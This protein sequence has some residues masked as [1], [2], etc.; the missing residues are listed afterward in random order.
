M[1]RTFPSTK[2]PADGERRARRGYV[3]QDRSSARLIYA[4]LLDRTLQWIGLA[5]RNAGSVDDLVLGLSDCVVAHQ[6]KRAARPKGVGLKAL[7]LGPGAE[8]KRLADSFI[9]LRQQFPGIP[10]R[11]RYLSN[12]FPSP[13]DKLVPRTSKSSTADFVDVIASTSKRSLAEWRR[14]KWAP[15]I[16]QL[17]EASKLTETDF[18]LFWSSLELVLGAA[19]LGAFEPSQDQECEKQIEELSRA[20]STLV[21]DHDQ[22]RWTREELLEVLNWPDRYAQHYIHSFPVGKYVQRNEETEADLNAKIAVHTKG[23]VSLIGPPGVGKSTLLQSELHDGAGIHLLRYLAFIPGRAQGQGRGE[24]DSFY[25]D[26]SSQFAGLGLRPPRVKED[27]TGARREAFEVLLEKAGE[28]FR[29]RGRRY[30]IVLDGLDHIPREEC[31]DRSLLKA[32]PLPQSLPEGVLFVL[33][34]Q[35]LDLKDIPPSVVEE[36]NDEDRRVYVSPLPE[37]AVAAMANAMGLPIEIS[38]AEIY[39]IT[40]GHPLVSRYLIDKLIESGPSERS[41]LLSGQ[42][43]FGGE[44]EDVYEAAWRSIDQADSS[45]QVK[46]VLSLIAFADGSIEPALLAVATSEQAVESAL[47]QSRHLLDR[48]SAGWTVFHNSFRLFVQNK[49]ILKFGEPD[50]QFERRPIYR[51]LADLAVEASSSSPQ[52]WLQF[53]YLFLAGDLDAAL[54]VAGRSYFADQYCMGRAAAEVKGDISDALRA[55][56]GR[57]DPSKLFDVLLASDEVERRGNVIEGATSLIDA[58]LAVGDLASA[59]DALSTVNDDGKQWLVI[60]GLLEAGETARARQLFDLE[61]PFRTM[62]SQAQPWAQRAIQFLDED[63]LERIIAAAPDSELHPSGFGGEQHRRED[64]IVAVKLAVALAF[65]EADPCADADA[66][67]AHWDVASEHAAKVRI[68]CAET[69]LAGGDIERAA[70][71]V[72]AVSADPSLDKLHAS[73]RLAAAKIALKVDDVALAESHCKAASLEGLIE[74]EGQV[75]GARLVAIAHA[76]VSGVASRARLG[77]PIPSMGQPQERILRGIQHHLV[78]AATAIGNARAGRPLAPGTLDS[79]VKSALRF[80]AN[81]RLEK[82]DDWYTSHLLPQVAPVLAL[83][84]FALIEATSADPAVAAATVDELLAGDAIFRHWPSFRRK[85]VLETYRLDGDQAAAKN[86]LGTAFTDL[87][88]LDPREEMR[89][90]AEYAAAFAEVGD[91]ERAREILSEL[92]RDALGVFLPAKKDAQYELWTKILAKANKAD[93]AGRKRRSETALRLLEGL[94]QTEG[95]DM[96]RRIAREFLFEAAVSCPALAWSAGRRQGESGTISWDGISDALL[97]SVLVRSPHL[98]RAVLTVWS[99]LCLPWYG[100]PH[101]STT[102]DGQFLSDLMAAVF[103]ADVV[104]T[105]ALAADAIGLFAQQSHKAQLLAVL[106]E[107]ASARGGGSAAREA[108]KRWSRSESREQTV[109]PDQRSYAHVVNLTDIASAIVDERAYRETQGHGD[110]K[111]EQ[112]LSF[113][114]RRAAA[115]VLAKESWETAREFVA[116]HA[117]LSADQYVSMA[118]ARVAAAAGDHPAARQLLNDSLTT[119]SEG[120]SWPTGRGRLRLHQARHILVEENAFDLAREEFIEDMAN[121]RYGVATALWEVD[122]IFPVLFEEVP[123]I[124]LWDHLDASL[125][126]MR[127]YHLGKT[128]EPDES[129]E[130]DDELVAALLFWASTIGVPMVRAQTARALRQLNADGFA[131]L[132]IAVAERLFNDDGEARFFA[133][134]VLADAAEEPAVAERF[135]PSLPVLAADPDAGVAWTA[136]LLAAWW[137]SPVDVQRRDLPPF[138]TLQLPDREGAGGALADQET[139]GLVIDDPLDWTLGWETLCES[140]ARHAGVDVTTVRWRTGTFIRD[141]GGTE[142]FGHTGSRLLEARLKGLSLVVP[143]RRPQAEGVIRALRHVVGELW[144]AGRIGSSQMRVLLHQFHASAEPSGLPEIESCPPEVTPLDVPAYFWG[145]DFQAWIA[146]VDGDVALPDAAQEKV[147]AEWQ[148]LTV[149]RTRVSAIAERFVGFLGEGVRTETLD[150]LLYQLPRTVRL[151]SVTPLYEAEDD[152]AGGIASFEPNMVDGEPVLMIVLCPVLAAR[153]GWNA[154]TDSA[155]LYRNNDGAEMARTVWW[156]NGLQQTSNE[157]DWRAEGQR[158]VLSDKGYEQIRR[159]LEISEPVVLAWRRTES[160]KGDGPTAARFSTSRPVTVP[161]Q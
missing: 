102:R 117:E 34:T 48:K 57:S 94:E 113:S 115:R 159:H 9:D 52:C 54:A 39:A 56:K 80:L 129:I 110:D 15:L 63:Q 6:F 77:I 95:Y 40:R 123:W 29:K 109:K 17:L 149:R 119:D 104:G 132:V 154:D 89:E 65:A 99:H 125:Q 97:R 70:A 66:L 68:E 19:A 2:A 93:P 155:H 156:R 121:A 62:A 46:R 67:V 76:M 32:L 61:S 106:E 44:L 8:I 84:L 37:R 92:R 33:G 78:S 153:L 74:F 53:R 87:T 107:A 75:E 20:L 88:E 36:A 120:W 10:I 35:R 59:E 24:A 116:S 81:A 134:L 71:L 108:A 82:G 50:P 60:D 7:L 43:G 105:E 16:D 79:T 49:P 11:I 14:T 139:R 145:E 130:D 22:D 118:L 124:E 85:V 27:S 112:E 25:H 69:A 73:W 21:V 23:Y 100:E 42:H 157:D 3:H 140:I 128:V 133:M 103:Q 13:N 146:G 135:R 141:W 127:E 101:G 96:A 30:I 158:I 41:E 136:H 26:I 86:R 160:R 147:L 151:G 18:E 51:T 47:S 4:A 122:D 98:A 142:R 38:R 152:S 28:D 12:D 45:E 58:Y 161:I 143:Y 31:P 137:N 150:T 91:H 131:P 83:V 72:R 55:L 126:G 144:R 1:T 148:R 90:R 5:D 138:Y 64:L 111:R 114:L